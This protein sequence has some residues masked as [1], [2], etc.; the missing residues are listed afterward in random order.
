MKILPYIYEILSA[1][2]KDCTDW[3]YLCAEIIKQ[4]E[5]GKVYK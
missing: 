3:H 2:Q 1:M 4:E 5:Y